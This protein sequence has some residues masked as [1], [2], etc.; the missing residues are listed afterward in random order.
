MNFI[1]TENLNDPRI[2]TFLLNDERA[3]I[4]HHPAWLK[5]LSEIYN[6][7]AFYMILKNPQTNETAGIFPFVVKERFGKNK[8]IISLPSTTHCDPLLPDNFDFNIII[9]ELKDYFGKDLTDFDFKFKSSPSIQNF[10]ATSD[11]FVH[12]IEL[13]PTLEETFNSFGRRSIRRFIKN[14]MKTVKIKNTLIMECLIDRFNPKF[15]E[16]K[17]S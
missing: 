6:Y 1:I 16:S 5:A 12:I 2:I 11:Y 10:I 8:K 4:Y 3:S 13:C 17:L 7:P 9:K 15:I 14:L